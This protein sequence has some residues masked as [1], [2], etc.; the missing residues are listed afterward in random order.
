MTGHWAST[1]SIDYLQ[2]SGPLRPRLSGALTA[3]APQNRR[4]LHVTGIGRRSLP[5]QHAEPTPPGEQW[6]SPM[7][8]VLTGLYGYRIPV[9][10]LLA[11]NGG[12]AQVQVGTWA[13]RDAVSPESQDR[14]RDVLASVVRGLHSHVALDEVIP[15]LPRL[16][17]GGLALGIPSP[18]GIDSTDGSAPVDRIIRSLAGT[19]WAA[20]I[21][22][23]PVAEQ[24]I[25]AV[26]AQIL[27]E[28]R[29]VESAVTS[30]GASSPL[31]ELYTAQLRLGLTAVNDGMGT[32]AWR[33]AVYLLGDAESYPRLAAAWRSVFAVRGSV[34][35]PVRV[36]DRPEVEG[37]ARAWAMPDD[38]SEPGPGYYRRPFEF[39]TL[40]TTAQLA[41]CVHLPELEVP[42]FSVRE[43]P[44]F[45]VSRPAPRDGQP[46]LDLGAITDQK[47]LQ[48]NRYR[49]E[50]D[51]LTRHAFVCG[52]TGAGKTN[53]IM[54]LL[55]EA[56]SA[57]VPFL[58]IEPAKTEYREMLGWRT[59]GQKIRVFTLGRESV[60]P[61]RLNPFEV[62]PGIDVSTHLDLLKAVFMGSMALWIPLPQVLEQC[63]IELYTERGWNFSTGAQSL[64]DQPGSPDSPTLG[65]LVAAVKRLVPTLGFKSES[66][67]EITAALTTRLNALRRGARGLMLDVSRSVPMAEL[68]KAPTVIELEGLGDDADKAFVMGL[69]LTRLYEHR[70]AEHAREL[71]RLAQAKLPASPSPLAH[72]VV[73]EEAHRL[74]GAA[75]KTTDAWHADPQGAFVDTFSQMLAEVRAYGQA[76]VI[77]DQVPVRLAP[78]VLKNTNL[79]VVHRLVAGDDRDAM[80]AAMSMTPEQSQQLAMLAPGR[81]AVFSEGDHMPA[82]VAIPKAKDLSQTPAIDDAAVA[83]A[84]A[85]WRADPVVAAWF[86]ASRGCVKACRNPVLCQAGRRLAETPDAWLL[87]ARLFHSAVEHPDGLDAVW[88]DARAFAAAQTPPHADPGEMLHVFTAH[89]TADLIARRA[90]QAGWSPQT[91]TRL[92]E[93]MREVIAERVTATGRWL[94]ST[95]ARVALAA[96]AADTQ[97]RSYDPFPLC[98]VVCPDGRCAFRHALQDAG[99]ASY[100]AAGAET[101]AEEREAQKAQEPQKAQQAEIAGYLARQVIQISPTAPDGGPALTAA[102]WRA[103]ACAAQ[104]LTCLSDHPYEGAELAA[105]A[106][107]KAGW[108]VAVPPES[109][110]QAATPEKARTQ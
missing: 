67:Q 12:G 96:A 69:L 15:D 38:E 19:R 55:A 58:V 82:I 93:L 109:A 14:R 65:E 81:A 85:D 51:H 75:R 45:A 32:G 108:A 44:A 106:I 62:P 80:A 53:T 84:M 57:D 4:L 73:V 34:P 41:S 43:A 42:G 87:A 30:E 79:K 61:L 6:H 54:H 63:L 101:G 104:Q 99:V 90:I 47:P 2:R 103:L 1:T 17:L 26:R 66:T 64:E 3:G 86:T 20:L 60:A 102:R 7:A 56:A 11:D 28:I 72:I 83:A 21:L 68:L 29:T 5:D 100:T 74:L 16:P 33:S 105:A 24:A 107:T 95:P 39:Q 40:L 94:G 31:A 22:A 91:R 59:A 78:D 89:A 50:R 46:T 71:K 77:A 9:A 70:R 27:N 48:W 23:Y 97:R 18:A 110:A 35:E 98:G 37:L 76:I 13:A 25:G 10:Y 36:F 8:G 49:I 52:L 88:P 92:D